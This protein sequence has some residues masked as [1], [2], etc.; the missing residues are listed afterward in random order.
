MGTSETL[1][2]FKKECAR[3]YNHVLK[4]SRPQSAKLL[5]TLKRMRAALWRGPHVENHP[6]RKCETVANV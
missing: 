2:I 4:G 3:R 6:P 5:P 1:A